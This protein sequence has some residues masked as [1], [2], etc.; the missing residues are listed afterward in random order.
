MHGHQPIDIGAT[1]F[2]LARATLSGP[3]GTSNLRLKTYEMLKYLLARPNQVISKGDLLTALWPDVTVADGS[4]LQCISE[5]RRAFGPEGRDIIRTMPR[6]GYMLHAPG[7]TSRPVVGSYD[8][9]TEHLAALAAGP[10]IAVLPLDSVGEDANASHICDGI[11]DDIL[12]QLSKFRWLLVISRNSSVIY[13]ARA[14]GHDQIGRELGVQYLFRGSYRRVRHRVRITGRLIDT[15]VGRLVWSDKFDCAF[16]EIMDFQDE[17]SSAIASALGVAI[18]DVERVKA[19]R[20]PVE[21]LNAWEA[22][23]HGVWLM[24]QHN[25]AELRTAQT[26]FE[27]AI[28]LDP[29]FASPR[30]ELARTY[31]RGCS[32]FSDYTV[33]EALDRAE[34][35]ARAAVSLDRAH[36]DARAVLGQVLLLRGDFA[37][38]VQQAEQSL[39]IASSCAEG[40]G[41]KGAALLAAAD[42]VESR[43]A[44]RACLRIDPVGHPAATRLSQVAATYYFERSYDLAASTSRDVIRLAP[45][46]PN[47]HRV[48]A[49]SLGQLGDL[50]EANLSWNK[51]VALN[52]LHVDR[53]I[54]HCPA[55][56][57]RA[58][59]EHLQEG[60][61]LAGWNN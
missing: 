26:F 40:Y 37:G 33:E 49:A 42:F 32:V 28:K 15:A 56:R 60:L 39:A 11:A 54:R 29:G 36:P 43:K 7:V 51:Y 53:Q 4:V 50:R 18:A 17:I 20:K 55:W 12:T 8:D 24:M 47:G 30:G 19:L 46:N 45:S 14:C 10:S 52:P 35:S 25:P 2:D 16:D 61:R 23:L 48:L 41:V 13:R 22:H 21:D 3:A 27:K 58:Q 38:A 5:L 57:L 6:R 9:A 34:M 59:H 44:L 31:T 1:T